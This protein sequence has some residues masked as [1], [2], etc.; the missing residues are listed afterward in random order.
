MT[1]PPD[2]L[3]EAGG[4]F[5]QAQDVCLMALLTAGGV[6]RHLDVQRYT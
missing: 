2:V 4:G 3:A 6:A 5:G 1:R